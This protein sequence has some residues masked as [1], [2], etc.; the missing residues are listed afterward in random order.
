MLAQQQRWNTE[1]QT[2][3]LAVYKK[4]QRTGFLHKPSTTPAQ[5]ALTFQRRDVPSQRKA[6]ISEGTM[7][8]KMQ[9][10]PTV[11][12]DTEHAQSAAL[13]YDSIVTVLHR[14]PVV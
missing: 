8:D 10:H 13:L 5:V 7:Y 6:I 12:S 4:A 1:I 11:C 14:Q 2:Y 3:L 9:V